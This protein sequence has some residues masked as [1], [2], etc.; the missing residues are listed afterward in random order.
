YGSLFTKEGFFG[1]TPFVTV[2]HNAG[3]GRRRWICLSQSRVI[4]ARVWGAR[5]YIHQH[6]NIRMYACFSD[7]HAGKGMADEY[8]RA[9]LSRQDALGGSHPREHIVRPHP[10]VENIRI[11]TGFCAQDGLRVYRVGSVLSRQAREAFPSVRA[12]R[13]QTL[14]VDR[15]DPAEG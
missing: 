11:A 4:F 3:T 7:D 5:R 12:Q 2:E 14:G 10:F 6:R 9:V 13:L 15:L 1:Q 8:D